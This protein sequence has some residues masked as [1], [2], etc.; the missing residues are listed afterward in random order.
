MAQ[1]IWY[2]IFIVFNFHACLSQLLVYASSNI[3]ACIYVFKYGVYY[4]P[5]KMNMEQNMCWI[6]VE[7]LAN[8]HTCKNL[9]GIKGDFVARM[10]LVQWGKD[11][12][13]FW[14]QTLQKWAIAEVIILTF[15][16]GPHNLDLLIVLSR[17]LQMILMVVLQLL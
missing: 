11:F 12:V 6:L 15:K 7:S 5:R 13:L 10:I 3:I 9:F 2:I 17:I 1:K 8:I 14:V 16:L 4:R